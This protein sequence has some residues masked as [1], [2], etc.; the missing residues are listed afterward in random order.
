MNWLRRLLYGR[1]GIDTMSKFILASAFILQIFL[2]VFDL[3][4]LVIIPV[5]M[6]AYTY[7]RCFSKNIQKRHNENI[8]FKAFFKPV[9]DFIGLRHK[10][11]INRKTHKYFKCPNCKQNLRVPKGKG[12]IQIKCPK[13]H[14]GIIMKS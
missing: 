12:K 14:Q 11:W 3:P 10:M 9:T 4:L 8:K 7:F 2:L 13:C 1:Y 5:A 6:I